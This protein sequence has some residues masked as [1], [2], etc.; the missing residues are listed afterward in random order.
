MATDYDVVIVGGGMVGASLAVAISGLGLRIGVLERHPYGEAGQPSFDD[1]SIALAYGSRRILQGMGLWEGLREALC[2]ITD[3]HV[4]DRGRFGATRLNGRDEGVEAL[5]YVVENRVM[6]RVLNDALSACPDV[7]MIAPAQLQDIQAQDDAVILNV[8]HEGRERALR[9]ALLVGADGAR[10]RVR[11]GL[12][13]AAR[14]DD[15]AQSAVI[16]NVSTQFAHQNRAFERFTS[17]GPLALLPMTQARCS[18]VWTHRKDELAATEALDDVAFLEKLQHSF[19]YRL[20][21]FEKVGQRQ[22][23]PLAL[24]Q[25]ERV[26]APRT[27]LIGNAA[28]TLHP[29]AGQGFNLALRD[30]ACLAQVLSTAARSGEDLGNTALL[31]QYSALRESDRNAVVRYTDALVR[32][33]SNPSTPLSHA[34]ALGLLAVDV[35]AP[36]RHALAGQAMGLQASSTRLA[37][38]LR[39]ERA[40]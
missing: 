33:F 25:A 7:Q 38:G 36:L 8:Q 16:A 3:I 14:I 30:I 18:L 2:P 24:V 17:S 27:V 15:Y 23:Y 1:R 11:E 19:G 10:S 40:L 20:G 29:V 6:G 28:Q 37:R 21:R 34:R 35:I 26:S 13:M 4:S 9:V 12:G 31:A 5:G 22:S 32:V 39:L